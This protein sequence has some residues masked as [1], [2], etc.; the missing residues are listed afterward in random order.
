MREILARNI[1]R[2]RKDLNLTQEALAGKLNISFQ[3]VS[4]WETGQTVPD[5]LLIPALAKAL[6]VSTD[7]LMGYAAF[8]DEATFYETAY[9]TKDYIWGVEPSKAC[10][11]V[12]E[13]VPPTRPLKLLDV[14]CGEGKDAVFFARCG[15]NVTGFDISE[16]GLEKTKRLAD[17]IGVDIRTFKANIIDYRL[18][19]KYDII[20]SSGVL[21]YIKP[22]LRSEIMENYKLHVNENGLV[23]MNVFVNKPFIAPP[24]E[25]EAQHSFLW[26][27]GELLGFF[28]DWYTQSFEEY[29]FNCNSSGVLHKHAINC[30]L[31]KR[32]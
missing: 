32:M 25:D 28:S 8:K 30:L 20:Y 15:Y 29:I 16:A 23:C 13:V 22:K 14:G 2:F 31:S 7:K 19:E 21:H 10:F 27:S 12:M 24:P 26:N 4:K 11:K 18:E 3:A 17:K 1:S 6:N 9:K 5:T